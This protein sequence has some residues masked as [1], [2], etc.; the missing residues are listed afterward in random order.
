MQ[1][2]PY[3]SFATRSPV[4][5]RL[6]L[7]LSGLTRCFARRMTHNRLF[8]ER[9]SA[10]SP[11]RLSSLQSARAAE[12]LRSAWPRTKPAARQSRTGSRAGTC[13]TYA[14]HFRVHTAQQEDTGRTCFTWPDATSARYTL[15]LSSS[16]AVNATRLPSGDQIARELP[17][18]WQSWSWEFISASTWVELVTYSFQH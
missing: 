1:Y 14:I 2:A 6:C 13:E 16:T 9:C 11:G 8:S 17:A 15:I 4:I 10:F 3:R 5:S 7:R 18:R 12:R